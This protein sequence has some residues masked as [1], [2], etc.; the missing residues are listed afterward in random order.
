MLEILTNSE[1]SEL[2]DLAV[3]A[4]C[5]FGPDAK[6]L[7]PFLVT[8][9]E[10]G[11]PL[12]RCI[13]A[14]ALRN[15]GPPAVAAVP[16]LIR[17]LQE[18]DEMVS[19]N[20]AGA[21]GMIGKPAK[22]A[23][24]SLASVVSR[25]DRDVGFGYFAPWAAADA[26]GKFGSDAR[27]VVPELVAVLEQTDRSPYIR[28]AVAT[29]LGEIAAP[30]DRVIL[31]A[32]ASVA[33]LESGTIRVG[34]EG[35]ME[36]A[37]EASVRIAAALAIWKKSHRRQVVAWLAEP[38][39][40]KENVFYLREQ[41]AAAL[42]EIGPHAEAAVPT[43]ISLVTDW[44][45]GKDDCRCSS[46]AVVALGKIRSCEEAS[47]RVLEEQ[48]VGNN[49]LSA[50]AIEALAEIGDPAGKSLPVLV[51]ALEDRSYE[52][53]I[54][55][56]D[57]IRRIGGDTDATVAVLIECLGVMEVPIMFT[58]RRFPGMQQG[59]CIRARAATALGHL[60][61]RAQDAI[62]ALDKTLDDK[63]VTVREAAAEALRAIRHDKLN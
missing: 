9:F 24:A 58:L 25:R 49:G 63:F 36:A 40:H 2:R 13:M 57:A 27:S 4:A 11:N 1:D 20:A 50:L 44:K 59:A 29:A 41:A 30:G 33:K 60:G 51:G 61:S 7:V 56:A 39:Q 17:A 12:S 31:A 46:A 35:A 8:A 19:S 53:R 62:P 14:S 5:E 45:D 21:L 52:V 28:E 42:G 54:A 55:A 43:L 18:D 15:I 26:L 38:L 48:I 37:K 3:S 10:N 6:E 23:V 16:S 47:M 22:A 34:K 32:L